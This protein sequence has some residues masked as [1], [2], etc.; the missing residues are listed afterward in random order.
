MRSKEKISQFTRGCALAI[1][2]TLFLSLMVAAI[3]KIFYPNN[4]LLQLDRGVGVFEV[5]LACLLLIFYWYW[6][7]WAGMSLVLSG[8]AGYSLFWLIQKLPCNCL[9]KLVELPSGYT[10]TFDV[11]FFLAATALNYFLGVGIRALYVVLLVSALMGVVGY[12]VGDWV[13][14]TFLVTQL[15]T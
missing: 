2:L 1:A 7:T 13:F 14:Q 6:E 5:I 9:G 4:L 8:F 15:N 12:F 11:F 3:G 10:F